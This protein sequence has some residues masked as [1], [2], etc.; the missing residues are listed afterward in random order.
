M[1]KLK[2]YML[3]AAS[4]PVK[5]QELEEVACEAI[6]KLRKHCP[7]LFWETAYKLHCIVYGPHFDECLAKQAVAKM[8]NVD[9]SSGAHWSYEQ[10][11][12]IA[13]QH[14]IKEVADLYY[15]INMLYSD[16]AEVLGS[17]MGTYVK[18]AK[19]YMNDPDAEAGKVFR[20]WLAGHKDDE[21]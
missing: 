10:V 11:A 2:E 1:H 15:T 19:A 8:R 9:G 12:S 4:D 3:K 16:F 17:D 21:L 5:K 14:G 6:E 7:E 20:L 13:S 18:M